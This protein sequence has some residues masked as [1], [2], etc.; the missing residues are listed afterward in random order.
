MSE[1]N[2]RALRTTRANDV[3]GT[4]RRTLGYLYKG[5]GFR[6]ILAVVCLLL[7]SLTGVISSYFFTPIINDYVVPYIGQQNPDFSG[8]IRMLGFMALIYIFGVLA[9]YTYKKLVSV[10]STGMLHSLRRNG[11][12]LLGS[13][14]FEEHEQCSSSRAEDGRS[15]TSESRS[16]Q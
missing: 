16:K 10:I 3:T 14:R 9:S 15:E 12:E 2:Y 11:S 13:L 4:I 6:L 1:K 7:S 8:F 5:N